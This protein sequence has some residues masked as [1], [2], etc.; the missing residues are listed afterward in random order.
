VQTKPGDAACVTKAKGKCVALQGAAAAARAKLVSSVQAKCGGALVAPE[1]LRGATGLGYDGLDADCATELGHPAANAADVAE[2]IARRYACRSNGLYSTQSPRAGELLRIAGVGAEA[3]GCLPDYA[4]DG[5]DV[6]DP[7]LGKVLQG[8]AST[9]T[10][11]ATSFIG[12]KLSGL[13]KCVDKVFSCIQTKP[14]DAAC[15]T[16]ADQ[17]C[18]K[19]AAKIAAARAKIAPAIDK[20]CGGID[21]NVHLL[22]PRAANLAALVATLPGSD[23]LE[24]LTNYE[25]ALRLRH[26]CAAEDLL[27]SI[28]PRAEVLLEA[29]APAL[30]LPSAACSVP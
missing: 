21:F 15:L 6:G 20:K 27:R 24:N 28:A 29:F 26:E 14:G 10:K 9:I 12:K 19:E 18:G 2:C 7:V 25:T 13:T 16:K 3:D 5:E 23:T 22:P 30:A 8:C 17:A 11:A 4:G 1:N